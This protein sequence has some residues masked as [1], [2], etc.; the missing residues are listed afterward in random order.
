MGLLSKL[1]ILKAVNQT[2]TNDEATAEA[3]ADDERP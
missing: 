1:N 3:K 2:Y